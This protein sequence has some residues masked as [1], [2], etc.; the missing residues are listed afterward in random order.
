MHY[1]K[2]YLIQFGVIIFALDVLFSQ[3]QDFLRKSLHISCIVWLDQS[4][5]LI[6]I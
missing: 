4:D 2:V 3:L 5:S 6:A 1:F